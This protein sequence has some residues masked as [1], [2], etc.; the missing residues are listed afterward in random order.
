MSAVSLKIK[1]VLISLLL[2]LLST[3][4]LAELYTASNAADIHK[5]MKELKPG[6]ELILASGEWNN[7]YI[8]FEVNGT[9]DQPITLRAE[10]PGQTKLTG[11]SYLAVNGQYIVVSGLYFTDGYLSKGHVIEVSGSHNRVTDTAIINYSAPDINTRYFWLGLNGN[12]HEIDH[13][14]FQGQNHSGVTTVVWLKDKEPGQHHIHH[15]YYGP[16]HQ[17]NGNGFETIRIGTSAYSQIDANTLVEHNFFDQCDGEIE[18]ISNKSVGNVYRFNTFSASAGTLTIR[19]GH[20]AT[21]AYNHFLGQN[22]KSTGGVRLI[23]SGHLVYGNHFENLGGRASGVISVT[24]ADPNAPANGY[25]LVT[26]SVIAAN[27]MTANKGSAIAL[28]V[29]LGSKDRTSLPDNI[30]FSSNLID[31]SDAGTSVINGQP[32]KALQWV[33]NY[34]SGGPLGYPQQAGITQVDTINFNTELPSCKAIIEPLSPESWPKG[35]LLEM[36]ALTG[37]PKDNFKPLTKAQVGV[38]WLN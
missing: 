31:A 3:F 12:H 18:I 15:N 37:N 24:A 30:L 8:N 7:Q 14:Y 5:Y 20:H 4:S 9:A 21:I 28:D 22:K 17:G 36:C 29:G 23:G 33:N 19:H 34:V 16:R 32:N 10:K 2:T 25:Q 11:N 26:N 27:T 13:N 35:R 38:S 6:D 1:T